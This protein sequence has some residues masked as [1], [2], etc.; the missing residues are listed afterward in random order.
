MSLCSIVVTKIAEK[1]LKSAIDKKNFRTFVLKSRKSAFIFLS[2]ERQMNKYIPLLALLLSCHVA[3]AQKITFEKTTIDMGKILWKSPKTATFRF[4]N[5]DGKQPLRISQ[6]D[7]GCGC[8]KV[9][10]PQAAIGKGGKGEIKITYDAKLLG[11]FDRFIEVF[12]SQ[13]TKPIRLRLKGHVVTGEVEAI[14]ETFPYHIDDIYLNTNNIEFPDVQKGD[15]T[16]AYIEVLN[17]GTEV[18]E[19]QLM[20]LPAYIT[21]RAIPQMLAR[22]RKGKIQLTLHGDQ[23][24]SLGLNQTQIYLARFSGDRVGTGNDLTV[25]AVLLPDMQEAATMTQQPQFSI[26]TTQLHLGKLGKKSKLKSKVIIQNKGTSALT[27]SHIQSF[28]QAITVSLPKRELKPGENIKMDITVEAKYLGLS[29]AQPRVLIITN[30]PRH[31]KEVVN[32]L[33]ER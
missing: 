26:S 31:C 22:G 25:S 29:K 5:K 32:V 2:T 1:T 16:V 28:N 9:E 8:L 13:S 4:S 33:F 30:D 11:H 24:P 3:M 7:A 14:E 10:W 17:N 27:L 20:H 6:V 19:P 18:Y 23:M 21:A 12:T 15:S